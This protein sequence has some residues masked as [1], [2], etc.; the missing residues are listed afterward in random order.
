MWAVGPQPLEKK[1]PKII[2]VFFIFTIGMVVWALQPAPEKTLETRAVETPQASPA[3][4]TPDDSSPIKRRI[5]KERV[6]AAPKKSSRGEATA[7]PRRPHDELVRER[8]EDVGKKIRERRA[9]RALD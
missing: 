8:A 7:I 6:K 1:M 5:A 3:S 9:A 4:S 2:I